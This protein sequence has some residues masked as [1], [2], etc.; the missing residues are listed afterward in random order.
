[1]EGA[2]RPCICCAVTYQ[3]VLGNGRAWCAVQGEALDAEVQETK[4]HQS[5]L[6]ALEEELAR[7][8]GEHE[9]ASASHARL[10][11][12]LQPK[13]ER[14]NTLKVR[15]LV[16][17]VCHPHVCMACVQQPGEQNN[18]LVIP[19]LTLCLVSCFET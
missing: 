16:A 14:H 7:L 18:A 10:V 13:R 4:L 17:C 2:R 8:R 1:M 19:T 15:F 12:D 3:S 11:A 9:T 6:V 5:R